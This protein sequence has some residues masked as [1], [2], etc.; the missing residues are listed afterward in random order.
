MIV[1]DF[2]REQGLSMGLDSPP[3]TPPPKTHFD[4]ENRDLDQSCWVAINWFVSGWTT[5]L[6]TGFEK[7]PG[8]NAV[9]I[10]AHKSDVEGF[11]GVG[12]AVVE[13]EFGEV[14]ILADVEVGVG[15]G[16]G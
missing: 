3:A 13:E 11:E 12:D 15:G 8:C 16:E 9:G 1:V 7:G 5:N 4:L 6:G 14:D 2:E 10:H